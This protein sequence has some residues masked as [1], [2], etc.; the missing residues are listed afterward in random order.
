MKKYDV[1]KVIQSEI[2]HYLSSSPGS[3]FGYKDCF[4]VFMNCVSSGKYSYAT[5]REIFYKLDQY[6][7]TN[8]DF[9]TKRQS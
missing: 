9:I 2:K 5:L 6:V 3:T 7:K 1:D 8:I 4:A